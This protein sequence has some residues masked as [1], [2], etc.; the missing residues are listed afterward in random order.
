MTHRMQSR[1]AALCLV[2]LFAGSAL[3]QGLY[4]EST[5]NTSGG[6]MGDRTTNS[7]NY[8]MPK[9]FKIVNA[10]KVM[11]L[12]LDQ[13]KMYDI[14]TGTKTYSEMTFAEIEN[15]AKKAGDK[16]AAFREKIKNMPPDQ[17]KKMEALAAMMPGGAAEKIEVNATGDTKTV[18]GFSCS[19][20]VLKKG[21]KDFVTLWVTKGV[22]GFADLQKDWVEFGQRMAALTNMT[23]MGDAY[24]KIDG[25]PMETDMSMMGTI[26]TVVTKVEKRSTPLSEFE[27]PAGYTKTASPMLEKTGQ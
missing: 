21:G 19:K 2:L 18:S 5:T 12:R 8:A 20:Y 16:M 6:P 14:N 4:W 9:M 17:Q 3:A 23:G 10:P 27:V 24:K 22:T 11:I 15:Y 7:Q 1:L 25:F 26:Q 13:E